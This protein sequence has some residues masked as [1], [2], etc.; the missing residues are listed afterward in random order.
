MSYEFDQLNEDV[1]EIKAQELALRHTASDRPPATIPLLVALPKIPKWF[2]RAKKSFNTD[3]VNTAKVAE[4]VFDNSYVLERALRLI[5]N[6]MPKDFYRLLPSIEDDNSQENLPRAYYIA[7]GLLAANG[8]QISTPILV[9]FIQAYQQTTPLDISELWALP[10]LLRLACLELV[11]VSIDRMVADI[12]LPC[13]ICNLW[14]TSLDS[15]DDVDCLGRALHCLS[16]IENI[17]WRRVFERVNIVEAELRDDPAK[18]YAKLDFD[19][20]EK[21]CKTVELLARATPFSEQQVAQHAL[22]LA[23]QANPA[24]KRSSHVGYWLVDEGRMTL[25]DELSYRPSLFLRCQ[26]KLQPFYPQL[27][28]AALVFALVAVLSVAAYYLYYSKATSSEFLLGVLLSLIPASILAVSSVNWLVTVLFPTRMLYKID[29]DK[30]ID[31][32]C[33]TAV[34]IPTLLGSEHEV[35]RLLSH[36]ERHYLCN[37]DPA[38]QFVLLTDF[39]DAPEQIVATDADLLKRAR[40]GVSR[41]NE[42]H[43]QAGKG[44]FHLLHR[45]RRYNPSENCWMGWERKRGKLEQ[46]NSFLCSGN[47]D[48]FTTHEGDPEGLSNIR[49]VITLDSDTQLF[50]GAAGRLIGAMAH[51]LNRPVFDEQTGK[52]L[53]GYTIIQPRIEIAPSQASPTWFSRL[54]S[55]D[56]VIDIYTHAVSDVYQDLFGSGIYVGKGIYDVAAFT[57]SLEQCI[58]D[59]TVLSHDLFEG[60]HGRAALATD[61]ILYEEFPSRYLAFA[62]RLHRWLRGDWQLLPWLRRKV[63]QSDG[64]LI[65][66]KLSLI[67]QWKLLDNLRRSLAAPMLLLWLFAGWLYLP[68]HPLIWT[69]FALLAPIGHQLGHVMVS[70]VRSYSFTGIRET[71]T[72]AITTNGRWLLLVIF[73]PH[74]ALIAADAIIRTLFRLTISQRKMLEWVTAAHTDNQLNNKET[75]FYYWR[76]MLPSTL[77]TI[78]MVVVVVFVN[79]AALPIAAPLLLLWLL[80]PA[81]AYLISRPIKKIVEPLSEHDEVFLRRL[82]RRTWLFFETFVGPSDHWLPP[83][84][85]QEDPHG[86]IAHRTSPTNIGMML[87]SNLSAWDFG[88]LGPTE[89]TLRTM[90]SMDTLFELEHYRGHIFNWYNTQTLATLSPRYVS[91][92]DSGNLAA[93]LLTLKQGCYQ[94]ENSAIFSSARWSGLMDTIALIEESLQ[95][96]DDVTSSAAR[97]GEQGQYK[98]LIAKAAD[99][100]HKAARARNN[101]DVWWLTV[102]DMCEYEC[103]EFDRELVT[104]L[105]QDSAVY[106][107]SVLRDIR[108]WVGRV[109]QHLR[110]MLRDQERL[111]PWLSVLICPVSTKQANESVSYQ[112]LRTRLSN[113][114]TPTLTLSQ[115]AEACSSALQMITDYRTLEVKTEPDIA[116]W[117]DV[118]EQAIDTSNQH[119]FLLQTDLNTIRERAYMEVKGMDFGM[120]YDEDARL[121]HIGWN[122]TT[123]SIDP[124]HYDLLASEARLASIVAMGKGDVSIKHWFALGRSVT[125]IGGLSS[126]L[127]WGGTMFEYLMPRLLLRSAD[128]TLLAQSER[129]AVDEQIKA[130]N[131]RGTPWGIS[132]SGYADIDMQH[133]YQYRA[134]GVPSLGFKR[135]LELDTVIAPYATA[136]ALAVYPARATANLKRLSELGALS[137]YGMYEAVDFTPGRIPT[138]SDYTIVRSHMMHH[139]GMT[140]VALDNVLYGDPHVQRFQLCPTVQTVELLLHEQLPEDSAPEYPSDA[141]TDAE[142]PT[143]PIHHLPHLPTWQPNLAGMLPELHVLGNGRLNTLITD[144]GSG[145][146]NWRHNALTRWVP[147]VTEDN[148]GVWIYIKDEDSGQLWSV[149]RQPVRDAGGKSEVTFHT[150]MAEFNRQ[151]HGIAVHMELTVAAND[152]AEIRRISVTNETERERR[153]SIT[154]YAEVVLTPPKEDERHPAFSKLFIHSEV[155]NNMNALIFERKSRAP[156]ESPPALMHRLIAESPSVWL[157][158]FETDRERFLGRNGS[159]SAPLAIDKGLSQTLGWTL[160]PVMSLQARVTLAPYTSETMAFIT[161]AGGSRRSLFEVAQRY[162]ALSSVDL[163]FHDSLYKTSRDIQRFEYAIPYLPLLQKLLSLL[164]QSHKALRADTHIIADNRLGQPAL[165]SFGLSGDIPILLLHQSDVSNVALLR[166]LLCGHQRWY[167]LGIRIDL[168]IM[169]EG[170]TGYIDEVGERVQKLLHKLGAQGLLGQRG[171]IHRIHPD[172]VS[173]SQR[174]VIEASAHVILSDKS[175]LA[176]QLSGLQSKI[177]YLPVMVA[178]MTPP[179]SPVIPPLK[180]RTDLLYSNDIGGFSNGGTEYVI[181]REEDQVTP[182]PWCN[183][184]ANPTFGTLVSEVGSG[185]T[186]AIN[187]GENRLSQWAN[188][189]VVDRP[190]EAVYLR[191]EQTTELWTVTPKP[192][193][194]GS[195]CEITHGAG[196]SQWRSNRH[197]LEQTL[198]ISVAHED[199]VKITRLRLRNT[200]GENKRF[201]ATYYAELVLGVTRSAGGAHIVTEF[202]SKSGALLA[203]NVWNNDFGERVAFLCSD[204]PIHAVSCDRTEF[205]GREGNLNKPKGLQRWGLSGATGAALDPCFVLQIHLDLAANSET[206][207]VFFF[208]QADNANHAQQLI[209]K[210]QQAQTAENDWTA[211]SE[212]WQRLF[213]SLVVRTPEPSFDLMMNQWFIYQTLVC[214]IFARSGLYQ[215]SGAYGFRDQLQDVMAIVPAEPALARRHILD[216]AAH[217]FSLGDVLHWWHPPS[218]RGVRTRCSDDLLWLPYVTAHY[219]KVSGDVM[220]LHEKVPFLR[221]D[222]LGPREESR[223]CHYESTAKTYTLYEHCRRALERGI[224]TSGKHGLLAIGT[225][226]WNDGMDRVGARGKGESIWLSWFA[227]AVI[228]SFSSLSTLCPEFDYPVHWQERAKELQQAIE[229]HGWDGEWYLRAYDDEG[230]RWGAKQCLEC[231]ID[232]IAQSW[233]SISGAAPSK[234]ARQALV[235]AERELVDEDNKIV[236]LLWPAFDATM[237]DPGYIKAYPPGVRENGGQ[238]THAATWLAWAHTKQGDG[239]AAM[240]LLQ[241]I[242]PVEHTKTLEDVNTYRDEPYVLAGDVASLS[243]HVGRGGW[244]WYTGSSAWAYRLGMEAILGIQYRGQYLTI[245]PCIPKSWQGYSATIERNGGV[246]ELTVQDDD[247]VGQ[248]VLEVVIDGKISAGNE[249]GLPLA[250]ITRHVVVKL[251]AI[252][253]RMTAS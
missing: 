172:Q 206:E 135:G 114:L 49:F 64:K 208:G 38:I 16:V 196:F 136:L 156:Q 184:L 1:I 180:K 61:I 87:L 248:G 46:F 6:D 94:I 124:H 162:E 245:E 59:N 201:T 178:T 112:E 34:V 219:I 229:D 89:F 242:N 169:H 217:Q 198:T 138:S 240:R 32:D 26:R 159:A 10:T 53:V 21:Y 4:W 119:V 72:E 108:I 226:D 147:D 63:R 83:D 15:L 170:S 66:N 121:F 204:H 221:G 22:T 97:V 91:T 92:V 207:L 13:K 42:K 174:N 19:S 84:N 25:E 153:L 98:S 182:A 152:D 177:D 23:E 31:S 250:G 187:S 100:R 57:R 129:L 235:S 74:E 101:I 197:Q 115:I 185:C 3:D 253:K 62:R 149:G 243:P 227:I 163:I 234:R 67:D 44:P 48:A 134:F 220:I 133:N 73:L 11:M 79:L 218:D 123:G 190:S 214:R 183:V 71:L 132:E 111:M 160:D 144:S 80:A 55:G 113:V 139:Q 236:R 60:I 155:I 125:K 146:M 205:I 200:S 40:N 99:I 181:Y 69:L 195:L 230:G 104:T 225:G 228:D 143:E 203:K 176:Q 239:D 175:S 148:H 151:N 210:W 150:H 88:Y 20:R 33:A 164:L 17:P 93:A 192:I 122:V 141:I 216:S 158:G 82:A 47:K 249:I 165:W 52:V 18:V 252:E 109:H 247:G 51:P 186:W 45:E 70:V 12:N 36:L 24:D 2:E 54:A 81:I 179:S 85:Y 233:A 96:L 246:I 68:G 106:D 65:A 86:T 95:H 103:Q 35:D 231:R 118:L 5:K 102:H 199:P 120:V 56:S 209:N 145:G 43:K 189:P 30:G 130:A 127:S 213:K 202:D 131:Q 76:E 75:L 232:S 142:I 27:Y 29:F 161:L 251:G 105:S 39:L 128:G 110:D 7:N 194:S 126:L 211:M 193:G 222:S 167:Q 223:Y 58:P 41:L 137:I 37:S 107:V 28:L 166:V 212:R 14:Q 8:I 224:S 78:T 157:T 90:A 50:R 244:S 215:S 237:R 117:L 77:L 173:I 171:G 154:S 188:D 191:D 140:L 238:Y 9:K 168:V 116:Q 241:M